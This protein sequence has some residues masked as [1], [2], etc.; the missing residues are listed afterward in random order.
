[1]AGT[2][3]TTKKRMGAGPR[4]RGDRTV[5]RPLLSTGG[6]AASWQAG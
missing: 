3:V 1:M 2:S 5:P 4:G 6:A